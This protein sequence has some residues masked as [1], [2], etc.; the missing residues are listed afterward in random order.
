MGTTFAEIT[1]R[2]EADVSAY[3]QGRITEEQI[4]QVTLT[5]K[6]DTGA[7]NLYIDEETSRRLGLDIEKISNS[8][9]ANGAQVP[10]KVT[11][12][13]EVFWKNRDTI[14][15]A[16]VMP[17]LAHTL[18]GVIPLEAMDLMVD[19]VNRQLVGVHG[20]EYLEEVG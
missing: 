3:R 1:L 10:C 11:A 16:R 12:P 7:M 4:R 8:R 15:K 9:V 17:G 6:V 2:N 5:A 13:V 14:C 19:T 18:L 20:S